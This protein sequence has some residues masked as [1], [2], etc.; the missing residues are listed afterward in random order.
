VDLKEAWL[1]A[2]QAQGI[3]QRAVN[4]DAPLLDDAEGDA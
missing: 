4:C 2:Y 3:D 1:R